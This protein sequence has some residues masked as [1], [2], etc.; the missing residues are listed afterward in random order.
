MFT[1]ETLKSEKI[2]RV[3]VKYNFVIPK[4]PLLP[5][6]DAL[7]ARKLGKMKCGG[8]RHLGV[9]T[10]HLSKAFAGSYLASNR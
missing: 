3:F 4:M 6:P 1:K 7:K 5:L 2:F 9:P 8:K 10:S